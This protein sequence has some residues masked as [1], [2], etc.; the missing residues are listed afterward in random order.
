MQKYKKLYGGPWSYSMYAD[1]NH[2]KIYFH[3]LGKTDKIKG[4]DSLQGYC[5]EANAKLIASAPELLEAL[6]E[7]FENVLHSS[8]ASQEIINKVEKLL[9]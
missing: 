6:E 3:E 9:A 2:A 5:G 4:S 8:R 1:T 7:L